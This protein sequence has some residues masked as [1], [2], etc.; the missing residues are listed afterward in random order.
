MLLIGTVGVLNVFIRAERI[1]RIPREHLGKTIGLIVL[2]NQA[3][4]PVSGLVV[5]TFAKAHGAQA[6]MT[7]SVVGAVLVAASLLPLVLKLRYS[8]AHF[9]PS[10]HHRRHRPVRG[11]HRLHGSRRDVY[12]YTRT[13]GDAAAAPAGNPD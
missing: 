10:P 1:K 5:A 13:D 6:V 3:S 11:R 4:L 8:D 9:D 7:G 2:L 12:R